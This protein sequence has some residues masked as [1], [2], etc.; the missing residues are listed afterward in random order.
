MLQWLFNSQLKTITC[1]NND[2]RN[3]L[4]S[5]SCLLQTVWFLLPKLEDFDLSE[6]FNTCAYHTT[7]EEM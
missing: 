5:L 3:C 1:D 7:E 2:C 4:L 6:L